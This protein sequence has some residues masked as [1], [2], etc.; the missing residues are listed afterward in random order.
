MGAFER[1]AR[2]VRLDVAGNCLQQQDV[3]NR[4]GKTDVR[5]VQCSRTVRRDRECMLFLAVRQ[6]ELRLRY[7]VVYLGSQNQGQNNLRDQTN[8]HGAH[9]VLAFVELERQ[10]LRDEEP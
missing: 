4:D 10:I 7:V 2:G 5:S 8:L 3:A 6:L 9:S 1:D